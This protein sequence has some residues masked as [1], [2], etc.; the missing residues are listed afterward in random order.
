MFKPFLRYI[1]ILVFAFVLLYFYIPVRYDIQYPR[2]IGPLFNEFF[3]RDS[4]QNIADGKPQIVLVG[5][6][7]LMRGVNRKELA[8]QTGKKVYEIG[9]AGSASALWYAAIEH[10]IVPSPSKP[11]VLIIVFRDTMLTTAGYR[12]NGSYFKQLDEY[13]TPDDAL[14]IQ[15]SYIN[16]MNPLEKIAERYFPLYGSRLNLRETVDF[17]IR[18]YATQ[19]MLGCNKSCTQY[20]MSAVFDAGNVE[21]NI[22]GDAIGT[23]ESYLYT[24]QALDFDR[25]LNRS[26]LPEIVRMANENGIQLVLVRAKTLRYP[27]ENSEP[28]E[29]KTYMEKLSAYL[30]AN[31]VAL[32]DYG[33]D[34][35]IKTE[36]FYDTLHLNEQGREIFTSLIVDALSKLS[37]FNSK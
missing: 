21:P 14:I 19:A 36:Y 33:Q 5:D 27:D 23:A 1:L 25:Q 13:A 12:V 10:S 30:D 29:L 18:Y 22:L 4:L 3:R 8:A 28:P 37:V 17:Y 7:V 24:P 11:E 31:N 16:L 9:V 35:R 20:A 32:F 15:R 2:E 6:S 34:D 26:F